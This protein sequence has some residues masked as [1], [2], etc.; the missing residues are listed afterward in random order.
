MST[1]KQ[2]RLEQATLA[3]ATAENGRKV[4]TVPVGSIIKLVMEPHDVDGMIK[5]LWRD[6][7]LEMFEP[8]VKVR[9]TTS[10]ADNFVDP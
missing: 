8:D 2:F 7:V 10:F 4:V 9:A 5:V 6:Q 3:V 1:G